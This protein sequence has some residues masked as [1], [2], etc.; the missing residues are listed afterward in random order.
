MKNTIRYFAQPMIEKMFDAANGGVLSRIDER[1]K[2]GGELYNWSINPHSPAPESPLQQDDLGFDL[3]HPLLLAGPNAVSNQALYPIMT[4]IE[5]LQ[6]AG[7]LIRRR[8]SHRQPHLSEVLELSRVAMEC[9]ASSIWL[10]TAGDR[11]SRVERCLRIEMKQL[12]HQLSF[13]KLSATAE[14]APA[15]RTP[16]EVRAMNANHRVKLSALFDEAEKAYR[17]KNPPQFTQMVSESA[18]WIDNNVPQHDRGEISSNSVEHTAN[19]IYAFG[20]SF[21]HGYKWA[22]DYSRG[23]DI[24]RVVADALAVSINMTECAA[25]LFES[26]AIAPN[27]MPGIAHFPE[28]LVPTVTAWSTDLFR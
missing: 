1:G 26:A 24:W 28:R 18:R 4:A 25:C 17:Y 23:G 3:A 13:L 14:G 11:A 21:I 2:R 15:N 22:A 27:S 6:T 9:A 20:S 12:K 10:M 19:V 16:R 8:R 7:V 5:N